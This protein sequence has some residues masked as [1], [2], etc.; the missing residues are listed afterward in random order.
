MDPNLLTE[1]LAHVPHG[2]I[3]LDNSGRLIYANQK[4]ADMTGFKSP[5]E[6]ILNSTIPIVSNFTILDQAGRALPVDK[7]PGRVAIQTQ[8]LQSAILRFKDPQIGVEH[9]FSVQAVPFFNA[10]GSFKGVVNTF[11]DITDIKKSELILNILNQ[12]SSKLLATRSYEEGLRKYTSLV[13]PVVA[14]WCAIDILSDDGDLIQFAI[15]HVDSSK[16]ALA[17]KV[18]AQFPPQKNQGGLW[19]VLKTG[20]TEIYPEITPEQLASSAVNKRH[21]AMLLELNIRSVIIAPLT[22]RN[23]VLGLITY[24]YS[25]SSRNFTPRDIPQMNAITN[26]AALLLDNSRLF[27]T[28]TRLIQTQKK[29]V[30]EVT[31]SNN[32][33]ALALDVGNMGVWDYHIPEDKISWTDRLKP[34]YGN[35]TETNS[36]TIKHFLDRII[37]EDRTRVSK[38]LQK[39]LTNTAI[40]EDE[41]RVLLPNKEQRWIHKIGEILR[42]N[43]G[44]PVR[45]ITIDT[46]ITERKLIE[47]TIR[48]SENKFKS[49]FEGSLD[50]ILI[51]DDHMHLTDINPSGCE[52]LHAPKLKLLGKNIANVISP[53]QKPQFIKTW[54]K[55]Q[56]SATLR[57][58]FEISLDG[59]KYIMEYNANAQ[60][61]P[62]Q[63]LF[64]LR[65]ITKR[66]EEENRRQHLLS[67]ASHELRTPITSIKVF[68]DLLHTQFKNVKDPQVHDYLSKINEKT[69]TLT[70]LI[71]DL[72]DLARIDEGK[73][74]FSWEIFDFKD[75][76]DQLLSDLQLTIKTHTIQSS[77]HLNQDIVSD[78][79]RLNQIVINLVKNAV[80][81]SPDATQ[82]IIKSKKVGDRLSFSVQDF[83]IGIPKK[84][85]PKIFNLYYRVESIM[86]IHGLGVGL[87]ITS[88][89]VKKM[90]GKISVVS[91]LGSGSTF[92]VDLPLIP[93]VED[94]K[95]T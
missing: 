6:M 7:L 20:Q 93:K 10:D 22:V 73:L 1:T 66:V 23:K 44:D 85:L 55:L 71:S 60:F 69:I 63:T 5:E 76:L 87:Y 12:V 64:V 61:L 13:V 74:E 88:Q 29:Y 35:S 65:D 54:K 41:Y 70:Q 34:F 46:D 52:F 77:G 83:G 51:V 40:F 28:A 47:E 21:R 94:K 14:D 62:G 36:S 59:H 9:W 45:V 49:V 43:Q 4:A 24:A 18:R 58:T 53:D 67:I 8:K 17:N 80:K 19:H 38:K 2:I 56:K 31:E 90:G 79:S 48:F 72:L 27:N 75:F 92:T 86:K 37:P 84:D 15:S 57:G 42:D 26:R 39:A 89:I 30:A 95:I 25:D 91:K 33:L 81:Y 68:V 11:Y 16:I 78:K 82:V 32:T 50:I 3:V